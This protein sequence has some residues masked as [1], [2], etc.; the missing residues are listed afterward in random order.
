MSQGRDKAPW[1]HFEQRLGLL[2]RIYLDILIWNTFKLQRYPHALYKGTEIFIDPLAMLCLFH[3]LE[4][5][6]VTIETHQKQ[7]PYNFKSFSPE[8]F[9]A[10]VAAKPVGCLWYD[11]CWD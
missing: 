8:W 1:V 11:F 6:G 2:V 10:V 5:I 4:T 7:L 9:A 3:L